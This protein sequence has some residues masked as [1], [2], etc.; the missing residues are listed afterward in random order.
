MAKFNARKFEESLTFTCRNC[1]KSTTFSKASS[2]CPSCGHHLF[3]VADRSGTPAAWDRD[4]LNTDPYLRQK[5]KPMGNNDG[6]GYKLTTPFDEEGFTGGLGG[7]FRGSE[8]GPGPDGYSQTDS[9]YEQ[10]KRNDLPTQDHAIDHPPVEQYDEL[11]MFSDP[12]SPLSAA[13]QTNRDLSN[14]EG[15]TINQQLARERVTGKKSKPMRLDDTVYGRTVSKL[16][17]VSR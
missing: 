9:E 8:G 15:T 1:A 11:Q 7:R 3:K 2:G 5:Q 4:R 6:G 10:Q 13:Q 16:R 17:G 12:S 14:S